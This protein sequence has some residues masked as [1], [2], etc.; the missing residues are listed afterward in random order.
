[1]ANPDAPRVLVLAACTVDLH[2]GRVQRGAEAEL[3][4]HR[5][6]EVLRYLAA[7]PEQDVSLEAL[8]REVFGFHARAETRAAYHTVRRLRQKI[9]KDPANAELLVTETGG[10]KLVP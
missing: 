3:L 8:H 6:R 4:T 7:R 1:M 5:E 10:Y 9:E 2:A